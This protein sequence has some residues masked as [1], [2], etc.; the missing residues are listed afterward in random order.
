MVTSERYELSWKEFDQC[1]SQSFRNHYNKETFSDVTLACEDDKQIKSHK[2]ILSACSPFFQKILLSNPHQ[3]PLI[4]LKG[5]KFES[6]KLLLRFMYLGETKVAEEEL[7][8]F[9]DA[10]EELKVHGLSDSSKFRKDLGL[11]DKNNSNPSADLDQKP[12]I[13][14][15]YPQSN[16]QN[17]QEQDPANL[18]SE[19]SAPVVPS[20]QS[21]SY[22]L[23]PEMKVPSGIL[24]NSSST[25]ASSNVKISSMNSS[26][27][28]PRVLKK[29]VK[30]EANTV[31]CNL[32]NMLIVNNEKSLLDHVQR[33]HGA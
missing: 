23:M 2:M 17:I 21:N 1:T 5:V 22:N 7:Q 12:V 28:A 4:Y 32:C 25:S 6:L 30:K 33:V 18:Y 19:F 31:R 3:N 26:M 8:N 29:Y 27:N 9:L 10:A 11:L 15:L 14:S 24:I 16:G 20:S 13:S